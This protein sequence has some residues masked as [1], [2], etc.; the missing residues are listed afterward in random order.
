MQFKY[1][2]P[3]WLHNLYVKVIGTKRGHS[4]SCQIV[5][6]CNIATELL[7]SVTRDFIQV[8]TYKKCCYCSKHSLV[9]LLS[10]LQDIYLLK[11]MSSC[12]CWSVV[13]WS[14]H[15]PLSISTLTSSSKSI[16]LS[17]VVPVTLLLAG[18]VGQR[19]VNSWWTAA[20]P[21]AFLREVLQNI[22]KK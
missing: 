2:G 9:N 20:K 22:F 10:F 6:I 4:S 21:V 16:F 8:S 15:F 7:I 1:N 13:G 11:L 18:D 17:V 12:S 3:F 5:F 14:T 19:S